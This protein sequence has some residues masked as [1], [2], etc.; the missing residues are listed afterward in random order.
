MWLIGL[1]MSLFNII[2]T[3]ALEC[4]S[5]VNQKCMSRPKILDI[6]EGVGEAL[7]YPYNVQVNKYSGSCNTLDNPMAKLCVPGIVKRVNMQ[8]YNFLMRLNETR[9]V[10]W[11]ESCKCVCKLNSSVCNN[12][13][14]WNSNTCRCDCNE[15]FAGMINCAKGYTWNP[16]ECQCD[17]WCKPGQYL[18]HKNCVCKNRLIDRL[19]EE[20]TSVINET[21][22]NN[23]DSD[24]N[25]TLRN[26]FIGLFSVTVLIGIICFCVFAILSGLKVKNYF[27]SQLLK[28]NKR[29]NRENNNIY[30]ISYKINKPEHDINSINNLYFVV[31]HLRGKIEKINGSKDRYLFI[32]EDSLM[33]EKNIRFFYLWDSII[34]KIKYLRGDDIMFDDNE[35]IIKDWNKI[36][37]SSDIFIPNDVSIN[38]FSL[39]I[40]INYV[41]E[42]N[43]EFIPEIYIN[44]GYFT[45]V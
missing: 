37:F 36:R 28:I 42:K 31:D 16:C 11:H 7:F 17:K 1:T 18:D 27:D 32:N 40:V 6:N 34:N 5:V 26:V 22:I 30:Y 38:F 19:I 35:V 14:I 20:C 12:K 44:E 13:Q 43:D 3:K 9:N 8:V 21:M 24:N 29:E 33:G 4:V 41:I 23:K 39:V 2:K 15:D 10:L 25:N 45:K